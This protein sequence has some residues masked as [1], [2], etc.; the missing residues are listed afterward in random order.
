MQLDVK[1]MPSKLAVS[2]KILDEMY[3]NIDFA[4]RN[5]KRIVTSIVT[6]QRAVRRFLLTIHA[7]ASMD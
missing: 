7:N 2:Y 4:E 5:L 3:R 6:I 1:V